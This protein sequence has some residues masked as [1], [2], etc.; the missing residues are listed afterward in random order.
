M[1]VAGCL[2]PVAS[3]VVVNEFPKSGGTWLSQM[4]SDALDLPFPQNR[5][6]NLNS[7]IMH[8]HYLSGAQGKRMVVLWRDG[9]DVVVSMYHHY[10]FLSGKGMPRI[11]KK[12]GNKL[13]FTDP[14]DLISN[15]PRF[16]EFAFKDK[17]TPK[18]SWS[19]HVDSW[20]DK[21]ATFVRY[22]D[23]RINTCEELGRVVLEVTGN[24]ANYEELAR[25]I[26]KY[27]FENQSGR[28]PGKEDKSSFVR[29]GI[30]GD[31]RNHF[32]KESREIFHHYAQTQLVQ[33]GYES[34]SSWVNDYGSDT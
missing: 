28:K 5:L 23:L 25:I 6:P 24:E 30:V 26:D 11:E 16:L 1:I 32:T 10:L 20:S 33:L 2:R 17:V 4:L 8:G 18:Y 9:R 34:D 15:L 29:K 21:E 13:D 14:Q 19:D 12:I 31:W 7:C 27:S 3:H 22:E